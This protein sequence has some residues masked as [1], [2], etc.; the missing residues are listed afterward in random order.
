[1]LIREQSNTTGPE[2][3]QVIAEEGDKFLALP[4]QE[5]VSQ[6]GQLGLEKMIKQ[7][8]LTALCWILLHEDAWGR[9]C[10]KVKSASV[11]YLRR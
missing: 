7:H 10:R 9:R 5:A 2:M 11:H 4:E 6:L 8:V 3:G 1:M